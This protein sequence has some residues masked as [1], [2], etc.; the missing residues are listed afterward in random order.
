M[1][2]IKTLIP[3]EWWNSKN[4]TNELEDAKVAEENC[5]SIDLVK[6]MSPETLC[7]VNPV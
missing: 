5:D 1:F 7:K 4:L 3:V 2:L 6:P